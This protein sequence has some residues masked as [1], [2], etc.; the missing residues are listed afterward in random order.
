MGK[1]LKFSLYC[2]CFCFCFFSL[3]LQDSEFTLSQ[4]SGITQRPYEEK[5]KTWVSL[6]DPDYTTIQLIS[7]SQNILFHI[8]M[9][10]Y[11]Q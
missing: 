9:N 11:M 5:H 2:I 4:D 7:I 1:A 3:I 10:R 6:F 8:Y